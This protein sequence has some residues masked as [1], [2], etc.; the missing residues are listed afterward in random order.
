[1]PPQTGGSIASTGSPGALPTAVP[2]RGG[3]TA[4]KL[5]LKLFHP[6]TQ[7]IA[8]Y[9]RLNAR[10]HHVPATLKAWTARAWV[11]GGL[12]CVHGF[13]SIRLAHFMADRTP[14]CSKRAFASSTLARRDAP[15]WTLA[16]AQRGHSHALAP[17]RRYSFQPAVT[18]SQ[19]LPEREPQSNHAFGALSPCEILSH[20][21]SNAS[22]SA[23]MLKV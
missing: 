5:L 11:S 7:V 17:L 3:L 21:S 23:Q 6:H 18:A 10:N 12:R 13:L 1:V 19:A 14:L 16:S 22:R 20:V 8:P 9:V 15:L 2:N 4:R